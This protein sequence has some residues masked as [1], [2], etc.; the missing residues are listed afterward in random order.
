M[1]MR[2]V[3]RLGGGFAAL[4][5][6]VTTLAALAAP[7]LAAAPYPAAEGRCVDQTGVLGRSL[8]TKVTAV[9]VRDEKATSD[10]IAVAVVP[11]TAGQSIEEYSTGLFNHWGVGKRDKDNGV[12]LVV[13]IDDRTLRLETGR[14]MTDRLSDVDAADIVDDVITPHLADGQYA[15][16]ILTGLDEVRRRI[17]HHVTADTQLANLAQL[18]PQPADQGS[19]TDTI[20]TDGSDPWAGS[21][22]P[23]AGSG[24]H[25]AS[26]DDSMPVWPFALV[27]LAL[28]GGVAVRAASRSSTTGSSS[29]WRPTALSR[30][31]SSR[32]S[33]WISPTHT[34]SAGSP[35][36]SSPSSPQSSSPGFG[37]GSSDGGGASGSW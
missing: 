28:I 12:L 15:Q 7:A 31:R 27:G 16:G 2:L 29:G 4:A 21:G 1:G 13:A 8:C 36:W 26:D 11:T 10:E 19:S 30:P 33:P 32:H 35:T 22:D 6:A 5:L 37:G 25:Q 34:G 3:A 14:G 23:W 9:L 20:I 24:V 18:A 17:G